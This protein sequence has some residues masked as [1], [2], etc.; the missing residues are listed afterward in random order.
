MPSIYKNN[1]IWASAQNGSYFHKI[2]Q[3]AIINNLRNF[4]FKNNITISPYR[5]PIIRDFTTL[6]IVILFFFKFIT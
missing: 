6:S 5:I 2:G 4:Y 3:D 1:L